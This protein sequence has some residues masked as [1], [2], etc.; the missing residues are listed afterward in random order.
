MLGR[1]L[2]WDQASGDFIGD[3]QASALRDRKRRDGFEL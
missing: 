1:E 2:K 3:D